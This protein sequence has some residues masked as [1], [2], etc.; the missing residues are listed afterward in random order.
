[1]R[2]SVL[3]LT[4][5]RPELFKRCINS[6]LKN[7]PDDCE[8]LVNND[9]N[10]IDEVYGATYFYEYDYNLANIYNMLVARSSGDYIYFL[11]DDDYVV[12]GFWEQI[13]SA[14]NTNTTNVFTYVP[15]K[16]MVEYFQRFKNKEV[17]QEEH[18]QLGQ[19]LFK[20]SD[21]GNMNGN[22]LDNDWKLFS[23]IDSIITLNN[24]PIF[25]QTIDGHDN[26]SFE[27]YC[28]DERFKGQH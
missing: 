13:M 15:W 25:F 10:D 2:V 4:H 19:V 26:I 23:S 27:K 12:D 6:V 1:M 3:I 18:F 14:T 11:E 28:S 16:G 24:S 8:I 5:N 7:K 17:V 20:R 9:S 21:I 22:R